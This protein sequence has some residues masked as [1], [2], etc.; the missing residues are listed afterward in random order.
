M[1]ENL[2]SWATSGSDDRGAVR[3]RPRA[4]PEAAAWLGRAIR[5]AREAASGARQRLSREIGP[6]LDQLRGPLQ[7]LREPR[8]SP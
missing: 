6:E 7:Q 8:D 2:F 5:Q 1:F 3:P 4:T